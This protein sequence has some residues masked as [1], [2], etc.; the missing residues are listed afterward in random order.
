M[1][2]PVLDLLPGE[3][4]E[5]ILLLLDPI[6]AMDFGMSSTRL[7]GILAHHGT[8]SRVLDKVNFEVRNRE[9]D[10]EQ[11]ILKRNQEL[12]KKIAL[13]IS[14]TASPSPLFQPTLGAALTPRPE[15]GGRPGALPRPV[16]GQGATH[17][18][19]A[20][21]LPLGLGQGTS[22]LRSLQPESRD[23]TSQL[24]GPWPL[25]AAAA[26]GG[27]KTRGGRTLLASRSAAKSGS[28]S[29]AAT[30]NPE[31]DPTARV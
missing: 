4:L 31:D 5:K 12:V 17:Q 21:A 14:T 1:S 15:T 27:S 23:S 20:P 19:Q 22:T 13:F 26:D 10:E 18:D 2:A 30:E 9:E 28:S 24:G 6:S 25:A 7:Q 29:P 11:S 16:T 3:L 8:F